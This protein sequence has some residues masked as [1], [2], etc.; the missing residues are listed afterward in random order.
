MKYTIKNF[1]VFDENGA[2]LE[3]SPI[4]VLTG[5]NNSGKSSV[6]KS[7]ALMDSIIKSMQE[8][9]RIYHHIR[10]NNKWLDFAENPNLA[11]GNYESVLHRGSNS[12][13][14]EFEYVLQPSLGN[15]HVSVDIFEPDFAS[16]HNIL[17]QMLNFFDEELRICFK[18]SCDEADTLKNGKLDEFTVLTSK[19]EIIYSTEGDSRFINYNLLCKN[20]LRFVSEIEMIQA[21]SLI[22]KKEK[23]LQLEKM[24]RE[25]ETSVSNDYDN[26]K[27]IKN[28]E[29]EL[30]L[31]N[32][33]FQ[34]KKKAYIKHHGKGFIHMMD[35]EGKYNKLI[36]RM[37]RDYCHIRIN[38]DWQNQSDT[39]SLGNKLGAIFVFPLL[40]NIWKS[41]AQSLS[42]DIIA[43]SQDVELSP[44]LVL[45]I[46]DITK[47]FKSSG[48]KTF[49][50]Y[51]KEKEHLFLTTQMPDEYGLGIIS[52]P[53][54]MEFQYS[55][56]IFN[57]S[58]H[59][60]ISFNSYLEMA[61]AVNSSN[62][63]IRID[64]DIHELYDDNDLEY[65]K[66]HKI[67][68]SIIYEVLSKLNQTLGLDMQPYFQPF[69]DDTIAEDIELFGHSLFKSLQLYTKTLLVDTLIPCIS[70]I[71]YFSTPI[72]NSRTFSL[73]EQQGIPILL[74]RYFEA[75]RHQKVSNDYILK[76][77][78]NVGKPK[79]LK[80]ENNNENISCEKPSFLDKW[81]KRFD[82][83][84][85]VT[86]TPLE[87]GNMVAVKFY[88]RENA[89]PFFPADLGY[90]AAQ[91]FSILIRI[92]TEIAR[93]SHA[94]IAL[95]EPEAHLHPKLQSLL[96]DMLLDAYNEFNIHF[97]V[98]TH[99][100]YL[101][102]KIQTLVAK[103]NY[104]NEEAMNAN[105]PFKVYYVPR[106]EKPYEMMFRTDG[107]F[108]NEFGPGFFDEASNL[109][110]EIL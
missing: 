70:N 10:L 106:G 40:S 11:L 43:I 52:L 104:E 17:S 14:L 86:I 34:L 61:A 15:C 76:V 85:S 21:L 73:S 38:P 30:K 28:L 66:S 37:T 42:D 69:K 13:T 32:K 63:Y 45:G 4:T 5:C 79:E 58:F 81:L 87:D 96:A 102:R 33:S 6:V 1:K 55:C 7:L 100:E 25:Y 91:L 29:H 39:I 93:S 31:L 67:D 20:F 41:K 44:E 75:K 57:S 92:E 98:E 56:P 35:D 64:G 88:D 19:N 9:Y 47:D 60:G 3:L 74:K 18:F 26:S 109:L 83:A 77:I 72:F 95:E 22:K 53:T 54:Q 99:S 89:K 51:Y 62:R 80:K 36:D 65:W 78:G 108:S 110:F 82:I 90:G 101:V 97:I 8:E 105:N 27:N 46:E 94:I 71:N 84:D 107:K 59:S 16:S 2:S 23:E 24:Q 68:F 48:C 49:G 103:R 50:E 12:R